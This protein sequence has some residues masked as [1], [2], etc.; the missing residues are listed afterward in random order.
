MADSD[1]LHGAVPDNSHIALLIIDAINDF[2]FENA[3]PLFAAALPAAQKLAAFKRR[4]KAAKVPVIYVNDNFGKWR[5]DFRKLLEHCLQDEVRGKPIAQLLQPDP[6]DYFV[7]KPKHSGFYSSVL[8]L[9]L[10]HLHAKLLLLA[11]F[12]TDSCVLFTAIDAYMRDLQIVIPKDCV[13]ADAPQANERALALM[14]KSL[15]AQILDASR[16]DFGELTQRA[17]R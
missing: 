11:G 2:E 6:D 5:T 17:A 16:I 9:L 1:N 7:L 14:E 12:A 13:A 10:D 3:E 4:A 15:K 8:P